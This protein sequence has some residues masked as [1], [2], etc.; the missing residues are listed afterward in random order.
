[1][2]KQ[3]SHLI[4]QQ[5]L[6]KQQNFAPKV[7]LAGFVPETIVVVPSFNEES[8]LQAI[9][10]LWQCTLPQ[11]H[12]AVFVVVNFPER[13]SASIEETS[14]KM[15]KEL[16]H[17]A[18]NHNNSHIQ[19]HNIYLSQVPLK[20]AGV[21]LA[22]KTGM[23]EAIYWF[24]KNRVNGL[25][26]SLDADC[27]VEKNYLSEAFRFFDTHGEAKGAS[28]YFEHPVTGNSYSTD[29]YVAI[30]QYELHLRYY[31]QA[32]RFIGYP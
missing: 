3:Q 4:L 21:G 5:Y 20:K 17:W 2:L 19:L 1:M 14:L 9:K 32:L 30:A 7:D 25:I 10:S 12:V 16:T 24:A 18:K 29:T 8:T 11:C 31:V 26:L 22:R 13:S 23:D 28:I 6:S 27:L 15:L